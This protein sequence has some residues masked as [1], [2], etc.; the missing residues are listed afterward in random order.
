MK[1]KSKI[2]IIADIPNWSFDIIAKLLKKELSNQYDIDI[3]YCVTDFNKDLFEILE[4]IKNY[5]VLHFLTRKLLLQFES[6]EFKMKLEEK[7]YNYEQYVSEITKKITTCVYDHLAIQ[8]DGIDYIKIYRSYCK[9]YLVC[10]QKLY[11][12]YN[13]IENCPKPWAEIRD[14]IDTELFVPSNLNRFEKENIINRPLIIG[15]VGNSKWNKKSENDIDYKGLKTILEVAIEELKKEG[16]E[17]IPYYA[18]VNDRYRNAQEMQEYYSKI[19]I[20][21]CVSLIEGT[22]R[23][24]L[25]AMSCGV[26]IITTDVGIAQEVL[27]KKQKDFI[28]EERNVKALKEKIKYLYHHRELLQ[29]LSQENIV[30]GK[31]NSSKSTIDLYIKLFESVTGNS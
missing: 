14:T 9:E 10:S 28:L 29:E 6:E 16:Y 25:E 15:W 5:D 30:E 19:D 12:I 11:D 18:D 13:N 3:F 27:G 2:A 22:P 23:P 8:E 26:P 17:V 7:G 24:L 21:V 1:K 4:V 20:Y 31:K